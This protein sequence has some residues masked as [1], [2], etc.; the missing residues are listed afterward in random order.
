[1]CIQDSGSSGLKND[2]GL[3]GEGLL[4]ARQRRAGEEESGCPGAWQPTLQ[5]L[6]SSCFWLFPRLA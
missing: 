6:I 1:M 4:V 5:I 3:F 2:R